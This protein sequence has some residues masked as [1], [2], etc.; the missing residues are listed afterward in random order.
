[1]PKNPCLLLSDV[2][3]IIGCTFDDLLALHHSYEIC[4]AHK[5]EQVCLFQGHDTC[6]NYP[7][8]VIACHTFRIDG[9]IQP[10]LARSQHKT[11]LRQ[12]RLKSLGFII[13]V[14]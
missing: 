3:N 2:S 8:R 5:R 14:D 4:E 7:P 1:M 6:G 13:E 9:Q 11:N 12:Q 10:S